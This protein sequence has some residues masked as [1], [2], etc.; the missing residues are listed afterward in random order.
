SLK[1]SAPVIF[2]SGAAP[3]YV[4]TRIAGG[5]GPWLTVGKRLPAA[6]AGRIP[7]TTMKISSIRSLA[8]ASLAPLLAAASSQGQTAAELDYLGD[9][10]VL[11]DNWIQHPTWGATYVLPG[12]QASAFL[13]I[14]DG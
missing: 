3:S 4:G 6:L 10:T 13:M 7:T 14:P 12:E 8:F 9:V 5:I 11:D 1:M 2:A